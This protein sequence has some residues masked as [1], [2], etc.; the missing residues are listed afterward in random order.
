MGKHLVGEHHY[1]LHFYCLRSK[2]MAIDGC[3]VA[4][5]RHPFSLAHYANHPPA[6][7]RPNIMIAAYDFREEG[8]FCWSDISTCHSQ[9]YHHTF[10]PTGAS[11]G[12]RSLRCWI[13]NWLL[14]TRRLHVWSMCL[15]CKS[16]LVRMM[17]GQDS[18]GLADNLRRYIPNV[19]FRSCPATP[20]DSPAFPGRV[21][22]ACE[23]QS[24]PCS[25]K[26][27]LIR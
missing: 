21:L 15:W 7:R 24:I 2:F 17:T 14:E 10:T 25:S 19:M 26:H 18:V 1:P 27:S 13:Q 6:G 4:Q 20:L 3:C 8:T 12:R 5:R 11:Y 22:C 23:P 16:G 9:S